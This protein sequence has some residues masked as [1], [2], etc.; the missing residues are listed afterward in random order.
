MLKHSKNSTALNLHHVKIQYSCFYLRTIISGISIYIYIPNINSSPVNSP[1]VR[2]ALPLALI[3]RN[4]M[5]DKTD[6]DTED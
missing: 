5:R 6:D 2:W 1:S 3:I 4:G